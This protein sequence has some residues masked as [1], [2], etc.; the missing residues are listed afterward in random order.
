MHLKDDVKMKIVHICLCC[1][2]YNDGWSYQDNCLPYYH[3]QAGNDVTVITVPFMRS[4]NSNEYIIK[5]GEYKDQNGLKIIRKALK[6]SNK[7]KISRRLRMYNGLYNSLENEQPDIIFI[8]GCQFLDIIYIVRYAKKHSN[9]KI[10]VDGHED[11]WNSARNWLSKNILHKIIWKRC[12]QLIEPYVIKFWGVLPARVD[13]LIEMYDL[14]KEKVQ[15]LVMGAEDEKVAEAKDENI[16]SLIREKFNIKPDDFLIM[17]G[18]KIDQNKPQILLLMEAIKSLKKNKVK[19]IVFGSVE[20]QFKDKFE[21]LLCESVQYIGWID[22]KETYKY[23]NA[24]ELVVFPGL[25]SVF[26]EQVVGLGKPCVF[27]YMEGFTHIDLGGNCKFLYEDSCDEI[28]KVI[29]R[30]VECNEDYKQMNDIAITKG[31]DVF[32]YKKIAQKSIMP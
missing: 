25:H 11:F 15:L 31:M 1:N 20:K 23:F 27:R 2:S 9:V 26:W 30:I 6:I 24:A 21:S 16:R 17:T 7:S 8:H 22:S 32:S 14:P 12:A 4:I 19:L 28:V 10:Y 18:G 3:K 29:S 13:F 5:V